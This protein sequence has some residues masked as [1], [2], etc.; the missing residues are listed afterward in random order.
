MAIPYYCTI[1]GT[2]QTATLQEIFQHGVAVDATATASGVCDII[3][4]TFRAAFGTSQ[5]KLSGMVSTG[6]TYTEVTAA[7]INDPFGLADPVLQAATHKVFAPV[8]TGL[9]SG[10]ML[11]AQSTVAVSLTGGTRP[12]GAPYRGR[13]YLPPGPVSL[14]GADG[15][16]SSTAR[17]QTNS[18]AGEW[19][20]AMRAAG[21]SP[22]VWSRKD[23]V[24][25]P[26]TQSRVGD[27]VDT[28]RTRRNKGVESYLAQTIS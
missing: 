21:A 25:S 2:I 6:I 8:L 18:W 12:N 16:L 17:T 20:N 9:G 13:F 1:R 10:N 22:C 26:V 4:S 3:E 28:M 5:S 27:R 15:K 7:Q 19:L 24:L 11:P 14:V 23:G